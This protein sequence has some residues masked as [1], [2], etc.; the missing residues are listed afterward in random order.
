MNRPQRGGEGHQL[1]V[2][3]G[4]DLRSFLLRHVAM[5]PP[6]D[7]VNGRFARFIAD[8]CANYFRNAGYFPVSLRLHTG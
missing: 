2:R 6:A 5:V 4:P 7:D 3:N 1:S 8:E